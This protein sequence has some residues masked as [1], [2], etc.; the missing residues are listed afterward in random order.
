MV[1]KPESDFIRISNLI[2]QLPD[3]WKI[4]K[5]SSSMRLMEFRIGN[6]S[7]FYGSVQNI[8]GTVNDN[9]ERWAGQFGLNY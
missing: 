1:N 9:L 5:P 4:M 7:S 8:G 6:S 2:A 3:G